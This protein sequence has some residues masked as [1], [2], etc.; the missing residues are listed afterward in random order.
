MSELARISVHERHD[1]V[2]PFFVG[3]YAWLTAVTAGA[4]LLDVLYARLLARTLSSA[5]AAA[6]LSTVSDALLPV[7]VVLIVA[8]I[9]AIGLS[10]NA[11]VVRNLLI[12]SLLIALFEFAGPILLGPFRAPI[13]AADLGPILRLIPIAL[14]SLLA[15]LALHQ[16]GRHS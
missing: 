14:A 12:A 13:E 16:S 8:A 3:L 5:E 4:L 11:A 2:R 7:G 6:V 10:W 15:L 9:A 1:P